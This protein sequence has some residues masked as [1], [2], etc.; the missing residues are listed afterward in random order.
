[1]FGLQKKRLRGK[2]NCSLQLPKEKG[3]G[4]KEV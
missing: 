2:S 4:E 3:V 1:M